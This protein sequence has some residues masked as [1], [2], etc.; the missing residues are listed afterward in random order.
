MQLDDTAGGASAA[1]GR[2]PRRHAVGT[3]ALNRPP[4]TSRAP[5]RPDPLR[6]PH[7]LLGFVHSARQQLLR[8]GALMHDPRK[9]AVAHRVAE[10]GSV[11][12][13]AAAHAR[14]LQA[15]ADELFKANMDLRF[16]RVPLLNV[17]DAADVLATGAPYQQA[18][19]A[20]LHAAGACTP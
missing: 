16:N 14:A 20:L 17:H 3:P 1:A 4:A 13:A 8:L 10:Q 15:A 19:R 12:D 5:P 9:L 11:L 18:A 6:R 7:Q 2:L